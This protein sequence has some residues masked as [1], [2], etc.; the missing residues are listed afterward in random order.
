MELVPFK[1]GGK[2]SFRAYFIRFNIP[3]YTCGDAAGIDE[4]VNWRVG[5][6]VEARAV[7]CREKEVDDRGDFLSAGCCIFFVSVSSANRFVVPKVDLPGIFC[8]AIIAIPWF[9]SK[10]LSLF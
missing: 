1:N 2:S 9:A 3:G 7:C 5:N 8:C 4:V 6:L 10:R